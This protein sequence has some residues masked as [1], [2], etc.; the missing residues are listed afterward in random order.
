L[1]N[2][3]LGTAIEIGSIIN[4]SLN[5]A[6]VLGLIM[7]HGNRVTNSVASTLMLLDDKTGELVFSVPTGPKAERLTDIRLPSGEGV[8]GWVA[9]HEKSILIP[10]AK[11][12]SRFYPGI[13]KVT[14]LETES[15][16]C[17]PLK[18]KTKLIGVLEAINKVDG[19]SF[20]EQDALFLSI[21]ASQASVAIE[22]ARL[23]GELRDQLEEL[24]KMQKELARSEKIRALGQMASGV[25]HDFNN[26]L[27]AIMGYAEMA[28]YEFTEESPARQSIDQVLK[29]SNRAKDLVNQILAFSRQTEQKRIP[30]H[31]HQ[32]VNEVIKL[33]RASLPS[34]IEIRQN[35]ATNAGTIMADPTQIHQI[36]LNLFTN[37][38][39]SMMEKGGLLEVSTAPEELD[40]SEAAAYPD[41]KAGSYLKLTVSDTGH[42]IDKKTLERIFDP[43]FTTKEKGVGTGM[44][45]AVVHGIVRSHGGAITVSSEPGKGTVFNLLFPRVEKEVGDETERFVP[46]PLGNERIL[47]VDDEKTLVDLG[48]QMLGRLGYKVVARTSS[49]E[50]LEA[51]RADPHKFDMVITDMTMPNM[52]GDEL[53]EEIMAIR[54]DVPII[55]CTGF[56]ESI[57][58]EKAKE[59]GIREFAMK[60]LVM[61]DLAKTIRKVLDK[62]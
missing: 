48:E 21:F 50:A 19:T 45:L 47:F 31:A 4:S 58:K 49:I 53:A 62:E 42:G 7:K 32:I 10:N 13:D 6:E 26:I 36:L 44:G 51:F 56:S 9:E 33:L 24:S 29:A 43:Y 3:K 52:T 5:L 8:A 15:I 54:P 40:A 55:I 39:H 18:A 12:D 23:Y 34:T 2:E 35:L 16:L 38:Q 11:E 61:S 57:T 17:V 20:T 27:G 14:G 22:N 1:D 46:P 60:P 37:A 41:L 28:L 59:M 30:V 25:A